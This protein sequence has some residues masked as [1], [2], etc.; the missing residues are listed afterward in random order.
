MGAE[1]LTEGLASHVGQ[2]TSQKT[3][4]SAAQT[5]IL[6]GLNCLTLDHFSFLFNVPPLL[7]VLYS[8]SLL[9]LDNLKKMMCY[10]KSE[11]IEKVL[12]MCKTCKIATGEQRLASPC[13]AQGFERVLVNK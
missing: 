2:F 4:R 7:L 6:A 13:L 8:D 10:M 9:F 5:Q 3:Q 1:E 12:K 11:A